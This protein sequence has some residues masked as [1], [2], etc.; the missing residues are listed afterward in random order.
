MEFLESTQERD[1]FVTAEFVK[2]EVLAKVTFAMSEKDPSLRV[3]KAVADY[4]S[5][6]RNLRLDFINCNPKKAAKHHLVSVIKP[7]IL[8]ALIESKLEMDK[9]ELKKDILGFVAYL[10][11]MAI[12]HDEH[13][14]FVKHKETGD[15]GMKNTGFCQKLETLAAAVLDTTLEEAHMEAPA[16]RRLT[17]T[18]R[19]PDMEGRRTRLE[20]E[21]SR[22]GSRRLASTRRRVLARSTI[23]PNVLTSVRTRLL[24]CCQSM[25]K[26]KTPTRRRTSKLWATTKRRQTT[27]MDR[28]RISRRR[29]SE[30]RSRYWQ[31]QALNT[32]LYRTVLWRTQGSVA[33]L[34]RS[35]Y[36]RSLSCC[37]WLSGAKATSR[38]A[39]RQR[40]SCQR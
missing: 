23:C 6:H 34:S 16:T 35:R 33:S 28:P 31:T 1:A 5:L 32:P 13:C 9:S 30:S 38:S 18:E 29:I 20:L 26:R 12:I 40:C 3:M 14:H 8:K 36:C 24:F 39:V 2:A 4:Y 37:T 10:E 22:P 7:A 25:R 11:K 19:S 17:V 27:G 21:S 15:Y